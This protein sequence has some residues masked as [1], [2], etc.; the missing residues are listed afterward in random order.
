MHCKKHGEKAKRNS[1]NRRAFL[2]LSGAA[3]AGA[4]LSACGRAGPVL[5]TITP[6][7]GHPTP[8][9]T[10]PPANTASPSPTVEP[11]PTVT[12]QLTPTPEPY[13][14]RVAVV[15]TEDRAE[16]VARALNL[17]GQGDFQGKRLLIKP[18]YNSADRAPGSTD[19]EVLIPTLNWLQN[20]GA[21]RLTI[22]DRSGMGHTRSVMDRVGLYALAGDYGF[23]V[24]VFD[25]LRA[26]DWVRVR[27]DGSHWPAGFPVARPV[28]EADGII[29]LCCLKT[30]RF[31]GHFT[32]SLKNSVG[33]VAKTLPGDPVDYMSDVLHRSPWQRELIADV[34]TAYAP[35]LVVLDGVDAFVAGGPER[36]TEVHPGVILAG[37]DR[38]AIDAVGVAILRHFGTTPAV[39]SGP[40]FAQEQI[41]RAAALGL[42]ADGPDK[43]EL[44]TEDA[45]S[46][47]FAREIRAILDQ[48]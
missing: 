17:L 12:V 1:I 7:P 18:N 8:S 32:L 23:D 34:N 31:G 30:H 15:R 5:E 16:G 10:Q 33:M 3:G 42:G 27:F 22:G 29:S 24:Q 38:V 20:H 28:M 40:I 19:N 4:V 46:G 43:I 45:G 11:I 48:G 41:A 9:P 25:E 36:G 37:T 47:E 39:Q 6:S 2:K 21:D 13:R 44:V 26:E 35:D 14:A